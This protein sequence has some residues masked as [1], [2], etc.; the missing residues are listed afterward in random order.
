MKLLNFLDMPY[1]DHDDNV[2]TQCLWCGSE[3]SCEVK[4]D[5]NNQFQCWRCKK[6]GNAF[7]LIQ[8]Y[9]EEL[10]ELKPS[11]AKALTGLKPG[12]K[13]LTLRTLGVKH[14]IVK[15]ASDWIFPVFNT[16]GKVVS[17]YRYTKAIGFPLATPKPTSCTLL[18]LQNFTKTGDIWMLEGH[19]DYAAFL[20]QVEPEGFCVLGVC[21][22]S[23]PQKYVHLLEHR[24]VN[25]LVD[26]DQAGMNGVR[27]LA[28]RCK[29]LGMLP[30]SISYLDWG[31][32]SLPSHKTVP[33]KF[34]IRDLILEF[35]K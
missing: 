29:K 1:E 7:S 12:I 3:N 35:T 24:V 14:R 5:E 10:P 11:E 33:E 32:I 22:S 4:T 19:W 9:Y 8:K 26:N 13:P 25:F 31:S 23:F 34:D 30:E 18:G 20:S 16:D 17:L 15:G 28:A 21:G 27:S 6:T 2:R